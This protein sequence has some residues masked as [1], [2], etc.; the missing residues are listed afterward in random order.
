MAPLRVEEERL[1]LD[2]AL[3]LSLL[4]GGTP[5]WR[6]RKSMNTLG[7]HCRHQPAGGPVCSFKRPR[8]SPNLTKPLRPGTS[9]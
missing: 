1:S 8:P 6:F 4:T 2:E 3:V 7:K 9:D 5:D